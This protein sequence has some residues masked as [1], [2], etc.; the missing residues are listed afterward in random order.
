MIF[1]ASSFVFVCKELCG[2]QSV[3][4]EVSRSVIINFHLTL[5]EKRERETLLLCVII[6]VDSFHCC[7][8]RQEIHHVS[9]MRNFCRH[10]R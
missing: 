1:S 3:Q 10:N 6:D 8:L 9:Y 2:N 7:L 4:F 5:S